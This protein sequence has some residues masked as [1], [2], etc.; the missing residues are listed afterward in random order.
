MKPP[1]HILCLG[2]HPL[3]IGYDFL[4]FVLPGLLEQHNKASGLSELSAGRAESVSTARLKN[5]SS[6]VG[7]PERCHAVR[8][9]YSNAAARSNTASWAS[10]R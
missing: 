3:E 9:R 4:E 1:P 8:S 6:F 5:R 7:L 2:C 10:S